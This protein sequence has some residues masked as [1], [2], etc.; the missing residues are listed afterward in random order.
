[1]GLPQR[2]FALIDVNNAY[3]SCERV[4][5]PKLEN[6]PVVV[7]SNNDGCVV[8]RSYEAKKLGIKMAVPFF[9]L[10]RLFN[11]IKLQFCLVIMLYMQKCLGVS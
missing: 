3:V 9:K 5:N 4:F 10:K 6:R 7:L 1:M 11:S 2:I 8:S